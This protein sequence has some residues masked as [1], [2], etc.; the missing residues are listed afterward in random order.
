MAQKWT[1]FVFV[2]VFVFVFAFGWKELRRKLTEKKKLAPLWSR[3]KCS[4]SYFTVNG[5]LA[6]KEKEK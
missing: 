1:I 6:K 3:M 2:F 5:I 4:R